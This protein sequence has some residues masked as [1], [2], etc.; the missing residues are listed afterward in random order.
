MTECPINC[1]STAGIVSHAKTQMTGLFRIHSKYIYILYIKVKDLYIFKLFKNTELC[2]NK[3]SCTSHHTGTLCVL[4]V[5]L[6]EDGILHLQ[7]EKVCKI[8]LDF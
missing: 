1:C 8:F 3:L 5:S 6:F 2:I 7:T 4:H